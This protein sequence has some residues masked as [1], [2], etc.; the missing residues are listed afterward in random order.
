MGQFLFWACLIES[1][2]LSSA[3]IGS[4][5]YKG[6]STFIPFV[7]DD[8][9]VSLLAA[10]VEDEVACVDL[11]DMK[12]LDCFEETKLPRVAVLSRDYFLLLANGWAC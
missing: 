4:S 9:F 8:A 5:G 10:K 1:C 11:L 12:G 7:D 2:E 6:A 3:S